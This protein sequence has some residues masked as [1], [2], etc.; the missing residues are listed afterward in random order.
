MKGIWF[1]LMLGIQRQ[2]TLRVL[3]T[4]TWNIHFKWFAKTQNIFTHCRMFGAGTVSTSLSETRGWNFRLMLLPD[5][6]SKAQK[7]I[8]EILPLFNLSKHLNWAMPTSSI[9]YI[10]QSINFW[11]SR[12]LHFRPLYYWKSL[13]CAHWKWLPL[14][15]YLW[16][17][18]Y[19]KGRKCYF[20]DKGELIQCCM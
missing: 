3:S 20:R 2:W 7:V 15:A 13:T 4:V 6:R 5:L 9:V 8:R 19:L 1:R 11:P 18:Q 12:K 16:S 17:L 10:Q 14:T